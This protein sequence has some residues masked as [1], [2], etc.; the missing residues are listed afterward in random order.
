M[1]DILIIHR[2]VITMI[3]F[4]NSATTRTF[5]ESANV[6][7]HYMLSQYYNPSSAYSVAVESEKDIK[8]ARKR[9]MSA[10][11]ADSGSIIY[12]S[13]ATESNNMAFSGAL[14]SLRAKGRIIIGSTEHPS[15]YEVANS[16]AKIGFDVEFASVNADGRIDLDVFRDLLT[17][18]TQFVSIMLVNNEVGAINDIHT[19][20]KYAKQANP[21]CI[22]HVDGVQGFLKVPF[23][24][25]DCDLF[26][27]SG[28]KFNA[29][30]GVGALYVGK[31]VKFAGGQLGG[32][33][34]GG[35]RSG[36]TNTPGIMAMD[37]SIE[38]YSDSSEEFIQSMQAC[39]LRLAKNMAAI[40]DTVLNGPPA[41]SGAPHIL[42]IS[43][44]GVRSEVLL[45][46]L[47]AR[48]ILV[49][50]GSACSSPKNS[51][52]R[53]LD[54]MN[55]KGPRQ[56]GAVRFSFSPTNT[57]DEVDTVSSIIEENVLLLRRYKKR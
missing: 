23:N 36:T 8:R 45:H 11:N 44:L 37:K 18:N 5:D 55:I 6:A 35:L 40:K 15:V 32:G 42:N 4:D 49:A 28:H 53:V 57:I 39:K 41:E 9:I 1:R 17:P 26:S 48:G 51:N 56:E 25:N 12:T 7:L 16:Y 54:A 33:Q 43:F 24:A 31:D 10:I 13:G 30:K 22:F 20:H 38:I 27:I 47:D 29:P 21:Q 14:Q 50:T 52:N 46:A 19:L 34:E 3:N 2:E